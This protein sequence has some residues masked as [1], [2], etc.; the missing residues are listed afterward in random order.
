MLKALNELRDYKIYNKINLYSLNSENK[1]KLKDNFIIYFDDDSNFTNDKFIEFLNSNLIDNNYFKNLY[2]DKLVKSKN[3]LIKIYQKR[4][5][6]YKKIQSNSK[7]TYRFFNNENQIKNNNIIYNN[8]I[9]YY[10]EQKSIKIK[11]RKKAEYLLEYL[12]QLIN[13]S[14]FPNYILV[15]NTNINYINEQEL[16]NIS[17]KELIDPISLLYYG[18]KKDILKELLLEKEL[19]IILMDSKTKSLMKLTLNQE[20]LTKNKMKLMKRFINFIEVSNNITDIK[21]IDEEDIDQEELENTEKVVSK[22]DLLKIN[23]KY[24]AS[25]VVHKIQNKY[26]NN[27]NAKNKDY[28]QKLENIIYNNLKSNSN[29]VNSDK[30]DFELE[31]LN[32]EKFEDEILLSIE[33][34][35]EFN[36]EINDFDN[37]LKTGIDTLTPKI[38]KLKEV[39]DN[40]EFNNKK[41]SE[42]IN[43]DNSNL[44]EIK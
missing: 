44:M 31:D 9:N 3:N 23:S 36:K 11:G 8:N 5:D 42:I 37:S 15:F 38:D 40:I 35:E 33:N 43:D 22:E 2:F 4:D 24:L 34:D 17:N 39:Q 32:D 10:I 41:L 25:K 7:Y 1:K 12:I 16:N 20:N 13:K 26:P 30:L 27:N 18:I 29:L 28:I 14:E 6:I 21:E 19:K